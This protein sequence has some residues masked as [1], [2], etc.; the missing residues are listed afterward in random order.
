RL[1]KSGS[2]RNSLRRNLINDLL[3]HER[4]NTTEAKAKAIRGDAERVITIAKRSKRI[5]S[6]MNQ[7]QARRTIMRKLNNKVVVKKVMDEIAPRYENRPGGYT[8]M[9]K[10]GSRRGDAARMVI[11]ELVED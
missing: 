4:I 9:L 7:V 2:H 11:L 8:R 3:V 5:G 10:L 1:N 6:S